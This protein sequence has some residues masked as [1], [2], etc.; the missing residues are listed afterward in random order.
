MAELKTKKTTASVDEFLAAIPDESRRH[1]CLEVVRMMKR[2][3]KAEPKMWGA[4]I[5]GFG[6]YHY[7]YESGREGDWFLT[8][9]SP[10][11]NDLTLYI[12]A[13]FEAYDRIMKRLGKHKTGKSCLYIKRLD[14]VDRDA[15]QELIDE[16]VRSVAKRYE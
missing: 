15:L 6:E 11:K 14:D 3:T 16:S 9:F 12:M 2:A 7:V 5:V 1:D 4:A 13:G 10:R 8:G